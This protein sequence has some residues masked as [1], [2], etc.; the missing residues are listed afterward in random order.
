MRRQPGLGGAGRAAQGNATRAL[1]LY[2]RATA[3]TPGDDA[4]LEST[5][6]DWLLP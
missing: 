5:A 4:L 3:R 6:Q 2:N 1:A